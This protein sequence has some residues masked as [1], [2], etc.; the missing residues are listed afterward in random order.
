MKKHLPWLIPAV[1]AAWFFSTL[2]PVKDKGFDYSA[3]ARLPLLYNGRHQPLDSFARNTLVQIRE[4]HSA[5]DAIE[6]RE[7]PAAEW[8]AEVMFKPETARERPV[9]R[10]VNQELKQLLKLPESN[11]DHGENGKLYSWDQI[12]TE[13]NLNALQEQATRAAKKPDARRDAFDQAV[14]KLG[15]ALELFNGLHHAARPAGTTNFTAELNTFHQLVPPNAS[16]I[17]TVR[18]RFGGR[19]PD[20]SAKSDPL[21]KLV[22]RFAE[23]RDQRGDK[24]PLLFPPASGTDWSRLP[25]RLLALLELTGSQTL[26]KDITLWARMGDAFAAGNIADFNS[27]LA[28]YSRLCADQVPADVAKAR[29]E[30]FFNRMAPFYNALIIYIAAF[31]CAIAYWFNFAE[32]LRRTAVGLV[33]FALVI[34]MTGLIFRMVLEGRPPVTNLYSSAIFIGWGAVVLGLLLEKFWRNAIGLAVGSLLGFITLIIAH[35]LALEG[36]T[37]EMLR[38]VLDTNFWLATHVVIVTLGYASTYVAGFLA[39]VYVARGFFTRS[40]DPNTARSLARMA[41]GILCFATLFSFVGTVLGGIWADQSW[42]RFWGWDPKENGALIIV[43]WN[44]LVLHARWGGLVKE[45]GVM[46]LAIAGNIV[47]SWSWFGVNMLGIGLHSYG[48]MSGAFQVLATFVVS[49]LVLIAIG[50]LPPRYWQSFKNQPTTPPL[51]PKSSGGKQ[52]PAVA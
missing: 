23:G 46:N 2:L 29:H 3:F 27:A 41:Y 30:V 39:I 52:R 1:F 31:L 43:L 18:T 34:H 26:P 20:E 12:I 15:N 45:R 24:L 16:A 25:Q 4:R 50:C 5:Y 9:F 11:L 49:Q 17:Q 8:L 13:E 51:K 21:L 36:D 37:M 40:L 38:A 7:L 35:N 14:L 22:A 32:W 6:K 10:V 19:E 47:T 48:F 33:S 28:D 44:A 42:G